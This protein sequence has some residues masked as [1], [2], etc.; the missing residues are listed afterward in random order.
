[1]RVPMWD[2][3]QRVPAS[4]GSRCAMPG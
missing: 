2:G 4:C 1:L 3:R